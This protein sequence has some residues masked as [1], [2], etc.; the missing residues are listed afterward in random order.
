MAKLVPYLQRNKKNISRCGGGGDGGGSGGG[1]GDGGGGGGGGG[2]GAAEVAS[3]YP[4]C[5][6][7][8]YFNLCLISHK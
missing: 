2:G 8:K 7:N 6:F 5:A 1:G 4:E 3:Q